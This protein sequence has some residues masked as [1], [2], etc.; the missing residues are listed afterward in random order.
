MALED[1][2]NCI[3]AEFEYGV[4]GGV[5]KPILVVYTDLDLDPSAGNGSAIAAQDRRARG[6]I[7]KRRMVLS[8]RRI[9]GSI[10]CLG[11]VKF[12]AS[13]ASFTA[14]RIVLPSSVP[15]AEAGS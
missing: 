4:T 2:P 8:S 14:R 6:A 15:L 3:H 13:D 12:R 7:S 11:P 1:N 5:A 9:I 10:P